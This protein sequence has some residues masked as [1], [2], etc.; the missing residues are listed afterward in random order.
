ME[1]VTWFFEAEA[2]DGI[3]AASGYLW[4]L[5]AVPALAALML[6][7]GSVHTRR[8]RRLFRGDLADRIRPPGVRRRRTA[9]DVLLLLALSCGIVALAGPRF[10]KQVQL[11][12]AKG[13]D[14][15]LAIDLSRSMD[16]EDVD[17]SRLER[18]R[19]E[20]ADLV[21]LLE[22]DRVGLVIYAGG[23]Y[24]RMPLSQ[25]HQALKML[26]EEMSTRDFQAQ[27]SALAEAIAVGA[28]LLTRDD[29]STAGKA[30]V[31]LSDG[32]VHD[33]T[34]V[35]AAAAEARDAGVRIFTMG[36][37]EAAAP[38]PLGGGHWQ[39]DRAG[40]R[41]LTTPNPDL[42]RE[43]AR[44]GGGAF[45]QSGPSDAD[46]RRLYRD[47]IRG[48]L[49]AGTREVRPKVTWRQAWPYP[50]ALG[51]LAAL[52]ASWLGEGR[53]KW[54]LA[55][56]V[57]L[58]AGLATM[59]TPALAQSL[60]DGDDAYRDGRYVEAERIFNELTY[61]DP[62]NPDLYERLGAARYKAGDF[63]GAARAWERQSQLEGGDPDALFNA[64]NAHTRSGRLEEAL[65]RYDQAIDGGH[66]GAQQNRE[67]VAGELERRRLEQ[68]QREQEQQQ[69]QQQ[70]QGGE[71]QDGDESQGGEAGEQG[72][73]G[74]PQS[75]QPPQ[76]GQEQ[77]EGEEGKEGDEDGEQEGQEQAASG[78]AEGE[79]DPSSRE[80][81]GEN[82]TEDAGGRKQTSD[83]QERK[84]DSEDGALDPND[85][86]PEGNDGDPVA[87][88]E[89]EVEDPEALAAQQAEKLLDG[90]KEG[91]PRVTVPGRSGDKPW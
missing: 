16:A 44:I 76:D 52:V 46:M 65:E 13:V 64:G 63:E 45:V 25:D 88:Q 84:D 72:A 20:V 60:V 7:M 40:R 75:G 50:L 80:Q 56:A 26:V 77:G 35:H 82:P 58:A 78:Q 74:Q 43:L 23:A 21:E 49:Q 5:L 11:V 68:Q 32:E 59:S 85:V 36:I 41:V 61:D 33:V 9:R 15:V 10:D 48:M 51:V 39:E 29:E 14:I 53:R 79:R 42:L 71:G 89:G 55:A 18:V 30:L 91:R 83:D 69:E 8:L 57:L 34:G 47:E 66:Q 2:E 3:F 87:G 70:Q 28:D 4:L 1:W 31:I 73:E 62:G 90:V 19:R 22:G 86:D 67:L 24:P 6:V 27:G 37:G 17:P 12:K 38:I 54:G 81:S